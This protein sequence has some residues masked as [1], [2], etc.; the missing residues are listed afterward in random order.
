MI[1]DSCWPWCPS[2][3]S[4][5]SSSL[6]PTESLAK[7]IRCPQCPI[8]LTVIGWS[9]SL[10]DSFWRKQL[11]RYVEPSLAHTSA[12]MP[13]HSI[14]GHG[15]DTVWCIPIMKVKTNDPRTCQA[16]DINEAIKKSGPNPVSLQ[17]QKN[18]HFDWNPNKF[19]FLQYLPLFCWKFQNKCK[20]K[21]LVHFN[22]TFTL[23]YTLYSM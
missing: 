14:I 6:S 9:G 7:A 21:L 20:C 12:T 11:L 13:G 16:N 3:P 15:C 10:H 17:K 8:D 19:C 4:L 23:T 22:P 2:R 18:K 1:Q 5:P